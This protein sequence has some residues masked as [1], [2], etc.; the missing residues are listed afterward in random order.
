MTPIKLS[1]LLEKSAVPDILISGLALDSRKVQPGDLFFAC[2]GTTL[3]GR[4]F[5]DDA[6]AKGVSAI[7][8]DG[9]DETTPITYRQSVP[10]IAIHQLNQQIS[11]IAGRFYHEPANSMDIIGVTGTNGKTSCTYFIASVLQQ[12]GMPCGVIGT[13]GHGLYGDIQSGGL[14]TPDAMSVQRILAEFKQQGAKHVA[15]EV[16]SHSLMQGRVEAIPFKVSVFTNLTQDHL[17]Y[18]GTMEA[19]GAAKRRLFAEL[20][21]QYAVINQ[22]DSFGRTLIETLPHKK[23]IISYGLEKSTFVD[24]VYATD[25]TLD[26]GIRAHVVT[27]WGEG[28]LQTTLMGQFNLSNVLAML[29]VLGVLGIPLPKS[30]ACLKNLSPVP[31]RMETLGGHEQPMVVV[32]YS[33]TPDSLE[34]AL[35]ALRPHCRGQL[36]CVFGC[37]GDRDRGKR[38]KMAAIA[39]R[40]ADHVIVTDDNPRTE[41]PDL[42]VADIMQGFKDP[43]KIIIQHDRS[44]A[45]YYGIQYAQRGDCVL[46]AGKGAETYQQIGE[47][48]IPFSDVEQVREIL[49]ARLAL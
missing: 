12:L 46:I 9:K 48:K 7:L 8:V 3:D 37:G 41:D 47:N 34:K 40:L 20:T 17:D 26:H 30:L 19:Y 39:E 24:S 49:N 43:E 38:P 16:S 42:I 6:I 4:H 23:N 10:V 28:E 5:I 44:K 15:M 32:D 11:A 31:G 21:T 1:E 27:P 2:Q 25:V 13:M 33:H 18:H 22:D 14:T 36:Y 29:G 45:I 35:L